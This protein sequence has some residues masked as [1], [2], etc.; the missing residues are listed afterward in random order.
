M[1]MT[2]EGQAPV[3][4]STN[5][6]NVETANEV[7]TSTDLVAEVKEPVPLA[8]PEP[9]AAV[10]LDTSP[11]IKPLPKKKPRKTWSRRQRQKAA[12]DATAPRHPLTGY[13]RYLN[14]HREKLRAENPTMNFA[15]ITRQLAS[16]WSKM[17]MADKQQYL[18]AADQDKERYLKEWEEYKKTDA[19]KEYRRVQAEMKESPGGAAKKAKNT[20]QNGDTYNKMPQPQT[21]SAAPPVETKVNRQRSPPRPKTSVTPGL[22]EEAC[23]GNDTDIQIFTEQFLQHNKQRET[24]LRQLRK[25][26]S[27]YEQQNAILQRHAEEVGAATERLREE[28]AAAADRIMILSTYR[29][30]LIMTLANALNPIILPGANGPISATEASMND[31]LEKLNELA[32]APDTNAL[33]EQAQVILNR[34]EM[35]EYTYAPRAPILNNL[36]Q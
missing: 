4:D 13:I 24:E 1:D 31:Y 2:T 21:P 26:N 29:H 33:V 10:G 11:S 22:G 32:V 28:A 16:V 9:S 12:R 34:I 25:A 7:T 20:A 23:G 36:R 15:E 8:A 18:Q 14:E 35:P 19:Y 3:V 6:Q 17:P 5:Q 27:D 30:K